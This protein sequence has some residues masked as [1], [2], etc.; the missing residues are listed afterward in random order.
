M[1]ASQSTRQDLHEG[2]IKI[3]MRFIG[4]DFG[5]GEGDLLLVF[6]QKL[7]AGRGVM[8]LNQRNKI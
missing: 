4:S 6:R 5:V 8:R 1:G 2:S 3:W 7:L